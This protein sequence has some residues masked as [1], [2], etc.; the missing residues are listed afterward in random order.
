[1][2]GDLT[3][4]GNNLTSNLKDPVFKLSNDGRITI[5]LTITDVNGCT[6]SVIQNFGD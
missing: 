6:S 5:E 4:S 1:M 2:I 3:G